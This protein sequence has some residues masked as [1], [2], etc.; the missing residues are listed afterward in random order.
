MKQLFNGQIEITLKNYDKII[1]EEETYQKQ[2][3]Y[4]SFS[5]VD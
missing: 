1:K 4:N 3:R 2:K 5:R